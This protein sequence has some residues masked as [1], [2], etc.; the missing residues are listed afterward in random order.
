MDFFQIGTKEVRGKEGT[1]E[2]FPD[3]TVGRSTDLMVRG[4]F[5]YAIYDPETKLWSRDEYDVQ[6]LVDQKLDEY[7]AKQKAAGI[8]CKVKYLR[9]FGNNGWAQFRKFMKNISDNSHEL[10]QKLTFADT[11]VKKT[12]YASQRLPYSLAPGDHSAWDKLLGRLYAPEERAKIE[13]S[14]GAI[15]S[16][17]SKKIQ[18]F[19][20]LY[21][22]AGTG[23]STVF[24]VVEKLF[25]GYITTFEAKALVGNNNSF[26]TEAF[27]HN[28]LVALQ[29]DGDLSKIEDNS[30][31]NSI[32]GH[33]LFRINEKFKPGYE[34]K[35]SAFLLMG[36][37]K[38]VKI[39]DAKSGIIRRLIDARPTGNLFGSNEYHRLTTKVEFELGAIA[40]HCLEV[41]RS[42]GKNHYNAY[43]PL[44]MMLQ[45]DV[46]YNFIE[47][48]IDI[49]TK[50]DGITLKQAYDLYKDYVKE[51]GVDWQVP[52]YKF[53]EELRNYFDEFHDRFMVEGVQKRS[54]YTGFR[55]LSNKPSEKKEEKIFSL[56]LDET[57]SLLDEVLANQP[58]QYGNSKDNPKK[59]WTDD[60]R[61]IDDVLRKPDPKQVVNT[62]LSDLDT[63]RLH[64]VKTPPQHIVVDF[65]LTDE[66]GEKS[67]ELNLE[68]ASL[69]PPTYMELSKSGKAL[70]AHYTYLGDTS[71]LAPVYED[72]IEIKVYEGNA[73]LRRRLT[74]CNNIP[75]ATLNGGLPLK[76][77]KNMLD[78][79]QIQGE[80][81]LR[82]LIIRNL[83]KEIHGDTASSINFINHILERA[84]RSGMQYD[85]SDMYSNV[86]SFATGSTNH[87]LDCMRL[88]KKMK[89]KSDEVAPVKTAPVKDDSRLAFLDTECF[90]NLFVVCWKFHGQPTVT[91]MIN[92]TP[93]Q[94]ERLFTLNFVGF[95]NRKYDNHMLYAAYLGYDNLALYELSK[96]IIEYK[97]R[98]EG[99]PNPH[100]FGEAYGLSY[101]DVHDYLSDKRGLKKWQIFYG[102]PHKENQVDWDKPVPPERIQ[103]IVD[104]CSN[105]VTSLE[106]VF[107][108]RKQDF[109]AREILADLS[110]LTVNDTT[111]KH[112][113]KIIF[114]DDPNPQDSLVYTD[115]SGEFPGYKYEGGKSTYRGEDPSEGGYVYEEEGMYENVIVL[116]VASM[117]PTSIIE[118][119]AFGPYTKRFKDIVEARLAIKYGDFD[120]ARGLLD[121]KLVKHI[122]SILSIQDPDERKAAQKALSEALKIVINSVY[123]LTSAKFTNPFRHR[124]NVDNIVAKRGALFMID[125][126][127]FVKER[128]F[129]VVHIKTDSIKIP[130][131]DREDGADII[132]EVMEFGKRYGYTFEHETTYDKFC[133]VNKAVYIARQ[134]SEWHAKGAQFAH[135][136]VYKGLFTKEPFT[137]DDYC[138]TKQVSVGEIY[139]DFDSLK[140]MALVEREESDEL[141]MGVITGEADLPVERNMHF[142]GRIGRFVPVKEG[143]GGAILY[144][145]DK[146]KNQK[147]NIAGTKG[148]FWVLEDHAKV[149]QEKH[150]NDFLD[151][152][153]FE[154]LIEK[155]RDDIDYYGP[156][157]EFV[158]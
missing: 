150:G 73:A 140:P 136:V 40:H 144:R 24:N 63:S 59:Y 28:P 99:V 1:I 91:S 133:L 33:D 124:R 138:E 122:D 112:S 17:D 19:L 21:G 38:P 42:M 22:K 54:Y 105:D 148:Y 65:D 96:K 141:P 127:H 34:T 6:R 137:F 46:F 57:V 14:I 55:S 157:A 134:G 104:Y 11:V 9:S 48:N 101:T 32:V 129:D 7:A 39:T 12:D 5:F 120:K 110:G 13:W 117:H 85:V 61:Y 16:G 26:S 31:L 51:T 158:A 77:N 94:V 131:G 118:L 84:Y 151:M 121:G 107:E 86:L 153:Y 83:N 125:L 64:F 111:N 139:M 132:T 113:G 115:L 123:G 82:S 75:I 142:V 35:L 154:K 156:F 81:G 88:V 74:R 37:N 29:H 103:E 70:H 97:D 56:T 102:L 128:G 100:L 8:E 149:L 2:I 147:F 143:Y 68:A 4:G 47:Y 92:P 98:G 146:K 27:K 50:Q 71:K 23:K 114:G 76:E 36:T 52:Q 60:E 20:V 87:A 25:E 95:N 72:G 108:F 44:E 49:F 41:Y 58:A 126:K 106:A 109:V 43:R 69:W 130:L 79:K 45:T 66:K 145:V 155:A 30:K 119:N 78:L 67:L 135:P 90:P 53:R 62:V 152:S 10:D 80:K 116:D 93:Q 15:L 18:K 3:F 89:F